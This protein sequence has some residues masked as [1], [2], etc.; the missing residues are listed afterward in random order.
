MDPRWWPCGLRGGHIRCI[1]AQVRKR[2]K[3]DPRARGVRHLAALA[4]LG[5]AG[6]AAASGEPGGN[7]PAAAWES[8]FNGRDLAGWTVK[9][10]G[11]PAGENFADTFRVEDGALTVDYGGYERFEGRF[12][13]LFFDRPYSHYRLRLEYRFRG[14]PLPDTPA[15]AIRNSGVML[16]AQSPASMPP[17]QDFPISIEFQFLGGLGDGQA[18]PTGNLCTPGTHV[19]H[20]GNFTEQHCID[21]AAPTFDGDDWVS[22]EVLVLGS[23]RVVHY[24]D[25]RPVL[26]YGALTTGGGVVSG[27]RPELKPEG[28]PLSRGHIALQGEGHPV[29]FRRIEL[30][31]LEGCM[32]RGAPGFQAYYV[33]PDPAACRE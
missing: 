21:S 12:A 22:V 4:G 33:E 8:L 25:G 16:H 11:Y 26:E 29:Q 23:E 15:W 32:E 10:R 27:H 6:W 2:P 14:D 19:V 18:R 31:N 7:A 9:I 24:V 5:I 13:H 28:A 3:F 20:E 30:L 1:L 17:G